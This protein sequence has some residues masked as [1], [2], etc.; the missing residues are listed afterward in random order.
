MMKQSIYLTL[1]LALGLTLASCSKDQLSER[2]VLPPVSEQQ[3]ELDRW[4]Q[5]HITRPY[6]AEVIYRW[7]RNYAE[8]STHTYPPRLEQVRP[9]LEAL[10]ATVLSLYR[11]KQFFTSSDFIPAHPLL[12]I[13]L[14]GGAN[15]DGQGVDLLFNRKAPSIELYI[16][17]VDTFSPTNP[18][19]VYRLV[20]SAQHQI[21]RHLMTIHPY[22]HDR[23]LSLG[24]DRYSSTTEPFADAYRSY[25]KSGRLREGLGLNRYAYSRGFYSILGML[26][27]RED[28][29]EMYSVTL[30]ETPAAI[31]RAEQDAAI[32]DDADGDEEAK[33]R[34]A[35]EAKIAHETFVQKRAFLSKYIEEAWRIPLQRLQLQSL[36]LMNQYLDK[37]HAT[38]P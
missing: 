7:D 10:E 12:H 24:S 4:C 9:V 15:R 19:E 34:Y 35:E 2:S 20:R 16:Y 18:V 32:P 22:D 30:T 37:H 23:F 27:A 26:G 33:R 31:T 3:S 21:G 25:E 38:Q 5:E 6:Q 28:L 1:T 17:N 36:Q 11:D 13:Y 8:R 14:Y 29:A